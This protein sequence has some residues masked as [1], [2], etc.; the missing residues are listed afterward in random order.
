MR[1]AWDGFA[2]ARAAAHY[3]VMSYAAKHSRIEDGGRRSAGARTPVDVW[4]RREMKAEFDSSL[5]E[6]LPEQ[7]LEMVDEAFESTRHD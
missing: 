7:W 6:A 3:S 4:L 2:T 5:R 1:V